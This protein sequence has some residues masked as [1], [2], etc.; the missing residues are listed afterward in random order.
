[1]CSR[2]RCSRVVA[3][4]ICPPGT[5]ERSWSSSVGIISWEDEHKLT[6]RIEL[7]GAEAFHSASVQRAMMKSVLVSKQLGAGQ[8]SGTG[9]HSPDGDFDGTWPWP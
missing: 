2:D 9:A 1:M 6:N 4:V 3:Y 8:G 7:G 5:P